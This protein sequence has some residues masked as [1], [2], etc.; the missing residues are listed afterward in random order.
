MEKKDYMRICFAMIDVA[1][2]VFFYTIIAI[3]T[4]QG[5]NMITANIQ[6]RI[7]H[8]CVGAK[9]FSRRPHMEI[10]LEK[11]LPNLTPEEEQVFTEAIL[12][13]YHRG[14][15]DE[16]ERLCQG[17]SYKSY[18]SRVAAQN[19]CNDCGARRTCQYVPKIGGIVRINC[20][21]WRAGK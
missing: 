17:C 5:W 12:E 8:F 11:R 9:A 16:K 2:W 10:K 1:D 18:Y 4:V 21:L 13:A 20:P 15:A 6:E 14:R 3:A 7:F 19:D